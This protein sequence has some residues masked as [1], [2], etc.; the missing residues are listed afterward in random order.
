VRRQATSVEGSEKDV[1][2]PQKVRHVGVKGLF[3]Y[4]RWPRGAPFPSKLD[5][6]S[7]SLVSRCPDLAVIWLRSAIHDRT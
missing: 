4:A 1:R 2:Q 5:V 6:A 7:S 3:E